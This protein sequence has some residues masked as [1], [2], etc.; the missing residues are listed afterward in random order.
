M[1]AKE[2]LV[3]TVANLVD[4]VP[5]RRLPS[6]P[7]PVAGLRRTGCSRPDT[8]PFATPHTSAP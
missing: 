1:K 6:C 3:E 7:H 2:G 4:A 5:V 8:G